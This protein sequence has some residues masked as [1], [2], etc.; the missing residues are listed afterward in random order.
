MHT[1]L[2]DKWESQH[3]FQNWDRTIHCQPRRYCQPGSEQEVCEIVQEVSRAGRTLRVVGA[4]H[5]WS[6]AVL[7]DDTLLNLDHLDQL[8]SVDRDRMQVTAGAGIRLKRLN[9]LLPQYGL[10]LANLGSIAEQSIAGAISTG[11]HGTGLGLGNLSTQIV[12]MNLATGAG[13]LLRLSADRDPELMA[14]ARVSLGALGVITQVT[15]QCVKAF[16]LRLQAASRPFDQVLAQLDRLNQEHERVRLYWFSGT[17]VIYVMTFG[18]ADERETARPPLVGWFNDVALRQGL[19]TVLLKSGHRAPA[20]VD[21]INRFQ[22]FVGLRPEKRT[23]RSDR[24]LTIPIPPFHQEM[25]YAVPVER[26][27]DALRLTRRV[28]EQNHFRANVPVEVRFVAADENMLSPAYGHP[29]CCA[30]AYTYGRDFACGYFRE[31]ERAMKSLGGRPHWAKCHT[32]KAAEARGMYPLYD[33][34]NLIRRRLDPCGTFANAFV[35]EL[36]DDHP[37]S[38]GF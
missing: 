35:R 33:R 30:G 29:V 25:E 20:L 2:R 15:I 32:L 11:T 34:F 6:P 1:S 7:T 8:V 10:A 17:D 16:N 38:D 18:P 21:P 26:A 5:S 23:A 12:G 9:E 22:T 28:I 37:V 31:F 36:F 3:T 14:A 13:Q 19:M 27:V 24:A 4:G